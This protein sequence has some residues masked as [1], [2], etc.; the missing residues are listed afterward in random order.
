MTHWM[1]YFKSLQRRLCERKF[2]HFGKDAEFRP[3]AYA[4]HTEN[5]Y[6]GQ[7]VV[8][9]PGC[10][11]FAD[12]KACIYINR[13]ALLGA[14]VHVYVNDHK[15]SDREK[16]IAEQGY[17]SKRVWIGRESWIGANSIILK[18]VKIGMGSVIGAG[19]VVT[20][21]VPPFEIWAGNPARKI[22][23]R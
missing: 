6:I 13:G 12:S 3:G 1:L 4:V 23:E 10:R 21:D 17:T 22:G 20:H 11:L 16:P 2:W 18:G 8:I 9:R 15:F 19:S 7:G 14:G 5:I